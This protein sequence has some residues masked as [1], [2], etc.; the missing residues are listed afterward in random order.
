MRRHMRWHYYRMLCQHPVAALYGSLMHGRRIRTYALRTTHLPEESPV[1]IAR[2]GVERFHRDCVDC[3]AEV[4]ADTGQVENYIV[5]DAVW[6]AAGMDSGYLCLA[7]L[8]HRLGR[9]LTGADFPIDIPLNFPGC[10]RDTPRM[11]Q[12]KSEAWGR[13]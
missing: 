4:I 8:E 6:A 9:L 13:A 7:C 1:S 12:L 5:H 2:R 10:Q 11:R 3:G